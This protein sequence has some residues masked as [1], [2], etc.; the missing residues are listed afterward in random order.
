MNLLQIVYTLI[1][2]R[3]ITHEFTT[4]SLHINLLQLT[5][6]LIANVLLIILIKSRLEYLKE[7]YL[8]Y[9]QINGINKSLIALVFTL[10]STL[11]KS[12]LN[13]DIS[14]MVIDHTDTSCR[15]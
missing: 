8:L 3:Y 12:S 9:L 6:G 10:K 1:Y 7:Q 13:I 2:Y 15:V 4:D 11:R 5:N 14:Y